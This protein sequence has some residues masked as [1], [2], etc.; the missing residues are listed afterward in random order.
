MVEEEW[1]KL[2]K[3][4]LGFCRY[5]WRQG[6]TLSDRGWY[7]PQQAYSEELLEGVVDWDP[8]WVEALFSL[9]FCQ[10]WVVEA[11]HELEPL[12]EDDLQQ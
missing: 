1:S 8:P 9:L 4:L 11:E 10:Q 7:N 5:F 3:D 6:K 12:A 2:I